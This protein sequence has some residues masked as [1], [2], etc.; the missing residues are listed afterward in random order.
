M[1]WDEARA[2]LLYETFTMK[3]ESF[4]PSHFLLSLI[5]PPSGRH[6]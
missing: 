3:I 6:Y 2:P 4:T 5:F 1:N